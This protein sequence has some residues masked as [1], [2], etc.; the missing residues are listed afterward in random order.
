MSKQEIISEYEELLFL[1]LN[2][3]I[4]RNS[5]IEN[6]KDCKNMLILCTGIIDKLKNVLERLSLLKETKIY[7]VANQ[8]I[9]DQIYESDSCFYKIPWNERF[10][11]GVIDKIRNGISIVE[12]DTVIFLSREYVDLRD[13]NILN[14]INELQKIR[15]MKVIIYVGRDYEMVEYKDVKKI[16]VILCAYKGLIGFVHQVL[17][18]N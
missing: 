2:K 16:E 17:C 15:I 5:S 18:D 11:L 1:E 13:M 4:I 12:I 8:N 9:L 14:I 7:I 10:T 3:N 6:L